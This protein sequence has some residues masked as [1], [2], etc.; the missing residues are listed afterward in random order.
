MQMISESM[1]SNITDTVINYSPQPIP[2]YDTNISCKPL[3]KW[4]GGKA[5]EL[6][7]IAP[8]IPKHNRYFEPFFGGGSVYFNAINKQAYINDTH[9]DLMLFYKLVKTH[10]TKFFFLLDNFIFEWNSNKNEREAIYYK[11]R[12]RYNETN[13]LTIEKAVDFFI[14]REYAYGGMFRVNLKGEFNVPFGYNYVNKD[15]QKKIDYLNSNSVLEKLSYAEI[16]TI[17][18]QR[19]VNKFKFNKNDFMFVDPPYH[20]S[21]SK[22]DKDDFGVKDQERLANYL[23]NFKGKFMLV[24]QY[25]D[26]IKELYKSNKLNIYIYDKKYKFNIK[27][28]FNRSVKHA[29]ITNYDTNI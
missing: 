18:F 27:G 1:L 10:N 25:T 28:R 2:E 9:P 22:Y 20:C 11:I 29:L 16:Y 15:I 12:K 17:D 13:R 8:R 4:P 26:L 23:L 21:F 19:F 24:I 7:E 6:S 14:L 3:L 5:S